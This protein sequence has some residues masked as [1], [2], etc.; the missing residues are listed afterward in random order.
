MKYN[1]ALKFLT[2]DLE[3]NLE[4]LDNINIEMRQTNKL[5]KSSDVIDLI[6]R[7]ESLKKHVQKQQKAL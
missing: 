1:D 6:K 7:I 4:R 2:K 3:N 5:K